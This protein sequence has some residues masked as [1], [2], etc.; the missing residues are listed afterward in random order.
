MNN[1]SYE[2]IQPDI[3]RMIED[4]LLL[5]RKGKA[6]TVEKF[7]KRYPE[8]HQQALKE[9]IEEYDQL[10]LVFSALQQY[11]AEKIAS[12]LSDGQVSAAYSKFQ[13]KVAAQRLFPFR[14]LL[15]V[16]SVSLALLL[17][18]LFF[19]RLFPS[20]PLL[21]VV[22]VSLALFITGLFLWLLFP[23]RLRLAI[24]SVSSAFLLIIGL[25]LVIIIVKPPLELQAKLV[26]L[27]FSGAPSVRRAPST[28]PSYYSGDKLRLYLNETQGAYNVVW[29]RS[30]GKAELFQIPSSGFALDD[31]TGMETFFILASRHPKGD[32]PNVVQFIEQEA[33]NV[34]GTYNERM[35]QV[36][37]KLK[38]MGFVVQTI[39]FEHRARD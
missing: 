15:A 11:Q 39:S 4:Y 36:A 27:R 2:D 5:R 8:E 16:V 30:T 24:V 22:S 13:E 31:N 29:Y 21:A 32:V 35:E 20:L 25:L 12:E 23:S 19:G 6:P 34:K 3:E 17:I 18:V 28:T 33:S 10:H 14:K 7:I 1:E 38:D 26:P 9:K 37:A